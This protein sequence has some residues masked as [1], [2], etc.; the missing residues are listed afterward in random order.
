MHRLPTNQTSLAPEAHLTNHDM[1]PDTRVIKLHWLEL[2]SSDQIPTFSRS[3]QQLQ[4]VS[5][6]N[7]PLDSS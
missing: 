4:I 1:V 5:K 6:E 3:G 7:P 2:A